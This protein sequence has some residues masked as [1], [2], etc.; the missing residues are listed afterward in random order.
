MGWMRAL[1]GIAL[2][3]SPGAP[4]RLAG[5]SEPSAASLLLMRT[6]GIR[7]LV[8]GVGAITAA[9]SGQPGDLRRWTSAGLA[10]DSIDTLVS[11]ASIRSIGRR[12]SLSAAALALAFVGGDALALRSVFDQVPSGPVPR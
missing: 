10:S 5:D 4:L 8:L 6:I 9:R 12:D 7:D 3:A 11:L 2:I 1:V